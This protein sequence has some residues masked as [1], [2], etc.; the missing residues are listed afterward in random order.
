M[1][2]K[3]MPQK[4]DFPTPTH[5]NLMQ[6]PLR[7]DIYAGCATSTASMYMFDA[8]TSFLDDLMFPELLE[9]R[10]RRDTL[11]SSRSS[12][13]IYGHSGRNGDIPHFLL[14]C[15]AGT[16]DPDAEDEPRDFYTFC[17]VGPNLNTSWGGSRSRTCPTFGSSRGTLWSLSCWPLANEAWHD[18]VSLG[19]I[20][21]RFT[22]RKRTHA[23]R[24]RGARRRP[25]RAE[26][27]LHT[28]RR[29]SWSGSGP[30]TWAT[31]VRR[32]SC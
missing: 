15:K 23:H 17:Q 9:V 28:R 3:L 32:A 20:R 11:A 1:S 10:P 13:R 26:S 19:D 27:A 21:A 6:D 8:L 14:V 29:P 5:R 2:T 12:S 31:R 24:K 16:E 4:D 30:P 25:G 7:T 22:K 18:C